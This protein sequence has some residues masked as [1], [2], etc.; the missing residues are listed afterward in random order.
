MAVEK[1]L[2]KPEWLKIKLA[3]GRAYADVKRTVKAHGLHT[4]CQEAACPNLGECWGEGTATFMIL[5][6]VCTRGC[7]FCAVSHDA[8]FAAPDPEEPFKVKAAAESMKLSH[9]VVTSVTRDDLADGGAAAFAETVRALKTITPVAPSVELLTPDYTD[10][11]LY[12]VLDALPDVFAHN[13]ETVERITPL[14][15]HPSF[16]F[17]KSLR[18]LR[19]AKAYRPEIFTKSSIMLGLG[20]TA[21]EIRSAMKCL[22]TAGVD[23]LVLGQYLRPTRANAAVEAYISE[24]TF[25]SLAQTAREM[26]FG[27]TAASPLARTSYR[28]REALLA[29]K[30]HAR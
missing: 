6:D 16:S 23:I 14:H 29:L 17:E 10:T 28:A 13:I 3:G 24:E 20:E 1:Y 11:P 19:Q 15:R 27:F 18:T 22:R 2:K 5:G 7:R 25:A 12:T 9:A 26:G 8:P 4:V 30:S 21:D